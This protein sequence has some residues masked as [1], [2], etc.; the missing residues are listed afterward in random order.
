MVLILTK[1]DYKLNHKQN[2]DKK[3]HKYI[4][5]KFSDVFLKICSNNR[6]TENINGKYDSETVYCLTMDTHIT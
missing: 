4:V 2:L 5:T 3:R 6:S 1:F